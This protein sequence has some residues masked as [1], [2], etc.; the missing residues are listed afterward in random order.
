MHQQSSAGVEQ[1]LF[2]AP[3]GDW[4]VGERGLA[5]LPERRAEFDASIERALVYAAATGAKRLH[6]MAG[7]A[8]PA[9]PA[10]KASYERAI[11]H[12]C[13]RAEE[14]GLDI[15]LQPINPRDMPGYFLNDF[16]LAAAL[17]QRLHRPNL[18]L[19]FDIYHR[20]IIHGDVTRGL[21]ALLPVTGH[22]QVAS[23]PGRH[24]PGF[25]ELDD[26]RIFQLLDE[27]GYLGFVGC[28]YWPA[29]AT[30]DGLGWM[31]VS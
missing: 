29:G 5:A 14:A 1:A 10:A 20:Q 17:I 3:P 16:N 9:D 15:L 22:V 6:V 7:I 4:Q 21:E 26:M 11:L 18:K 8:N 23:V 19:Q 31:P 27:M 13:D 25:G 2:N 24:E 12:A 28:E 30:L